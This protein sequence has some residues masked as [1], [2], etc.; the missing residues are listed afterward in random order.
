MSQDALVPAWEPGLSAQLKG[1]FGDFDLNV[2]FDAPN[3]GVTTLFGPPGGGKT[4]LLRCLA[5]LEHAE[6]GRVQVGETLWQD[7]L[8]FLQPHERDVG[9]VFQEAALFPH[10]TVRGNLEFGRRR[11]GGETQLDGRVAT[12]ILGLEHLLDHSVGALT[13]SERI[14]VAIARALLANPGLLLMDRPL[15][16]LDPEGRRSML[17][18]LE[19]LAD[20]LSIP[21]L[22]IGDDIEEVARLADHVILLRE[23]RVRFSGQAATFFARAEMANEIGAA[24]EAAAGAVLEGRIVER[25]PGLGLARVAVIGG[26]LWIVD[27]DPSPA[28]IGVGA[29]CRLRIPASS[30][31]LFLA[32]PSRSSTLNALPA[33]VHRVAM[34]DVARAAVELRLGEDGRGAGVLAHVTRRSLEAL[35]IAPGRVVYAVVKAVALS[36][37]ISGSSR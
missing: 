17:P 11:A 32:P 1:R 33:K 13:P 26:S 30:V 25:D 35:K 15:A 29:R 22:Y 23:G 9:C 7:G 37:R 14:R 31:S 16:G 18:Y 12:R 3:R 24:S 8:L 4:L 10:L 19:A 36:E 21:I 27:L 28:E 20:Q 5:G 6:E 2:N 34:V